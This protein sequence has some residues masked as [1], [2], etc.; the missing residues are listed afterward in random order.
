ML[1]KKYLLENNFKNCSSDANHK[2]LKHLLY[3]NYQELF[4]YARSQS[5]NLGYVLG[6]QTSSWHI[7]QTYQGID[8]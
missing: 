2:M 1:Q 8:E 7:G 3:D 4:T 6:V 5:G